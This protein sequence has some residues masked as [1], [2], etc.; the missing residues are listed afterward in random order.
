M[1]FNQPEVSQVK[2]KQQD[3]K[4]RSLQHEGNKNVRSSAKVMWT[5]GLKFDSIPLNFQI[6]D[7]FRSR[8]GFKNAVDIRNF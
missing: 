1:T 3:L 2:M 4:R 5:C 8:A 6:F 7:T